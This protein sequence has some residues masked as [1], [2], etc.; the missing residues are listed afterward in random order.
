MSQTILSFE[1]VDVAPGAPRDPLAPRPTVSAN[2]TAGGRTPGRTFLVLFDDL[3]HDPGAGRV[4]EACAPGLPAEERGRRRPPAAGH[5]GRPHVVGNAGRRRPRRPRG[6]DRGPPGTLPAGGGGRQRERRRGVP[7]RGPEGRG[8]LLPRSP[9]IQEDGAAGDTGS[10]GDDQQKWTDDRP[11]G[12]DRVHR[13]FGPGQVL[14]VCDGT[15][16]LPARR[17]AA[18]ADVEP[19]RTRPRGSRRCARAQDRDPRLAGPLP[20]HRDRGVPPRDGSQPSG[21]HARLLPERHGRAGPAHGDDRAGRGADPTQGHLPGV[22]GQPE[23]RGGGRGHR[24]RHGRPRDPQHQQ[25]HQGAPP[26]RGRGP[27]LLPARLHAD[28]PRARREVP[29]DPG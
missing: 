25:P 19:S 15:A 16:D 12:R 2:P 27:P 26:H 11:S 24:Q 14:P 22:P 28:E 10:L 7:D 23:C 29:E 5:H 9:P 18:A 8:D 4:G 13:R 3:R 1:A 21:Q 17:R 6:P 20:R